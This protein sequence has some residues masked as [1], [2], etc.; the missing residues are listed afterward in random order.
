[1]RAVALCALG[2][3]VAQA[4][5][6]APSPTD[7][8]PH[9]LAARNQPLQ[10]G[11]A[12][13]DTTTRR[14]AIRQL[15]DLLSRHHVD[16]QRVAPSTLE[17]WRATL[18]SETQGLTDEDF[19]LR[20]DRQ[21]GTLGDS[22]TR[23]VSPAQAAMRGREPQPGLRGRT[24][25]DGQWR[26]EMVMP[27]SPAALAGIQ[28][29]WT[30]TRID[31][32]AFPA[33]LQRARQ[34]GRAESSPQAEL[35]RALQRL[36][37]AS[38]RPDAGWPL[39][40]EVPGG[41]PVRLQLRPDAQPLQARRER[42][43]EAVERVWLPRI[44]D[45]ALRLVR[46]AL[47]ARRSVP[48]RGLVLDLRGNRGGAGAIALALAGLFMA[49]EHEVARLETR[50]GKPV[51]QDGRVVVPLV[52]TVTGSELYRGPLVL[53][54]DG[55]TASSAELLAGVLQRQ[56]RAKVFGQRSCGCMNPSLGWFS[57]PGGAQ[58]L[59]T[60]A[61]L[62]LADGTRIEG[63]GVAPDEAAAP[64]STAGDAALAA[65]LRSLDLPT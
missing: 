48:L 57:L 56:G 9:R 41:A 35:E 60:E 65:A 53:L 36:W 23:L 5:A 49:G 24:Q 26:V 16:A 28:A 18:E 50:D 51:S 43:A 22:H 32:E 25:A 54:V 59:I 14:A 62:P 2:L 61:R 42:V 63:R 40:F 10:T 31:G 15:L 11:Q 64:P 20:L 38:H 7:P 55:G 8:D 3:F 1:M 21:L 44:D 58:V 17:G 46:D 39:E 12:P 34:A 45:D 19:W 6:E 13:L 29:G 52:Q 37:Q 4:T 30:L 47:S 33:A 27:G